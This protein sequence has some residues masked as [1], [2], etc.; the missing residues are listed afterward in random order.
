[1][2]TSLIYFSIPT[3][4]KLL[5]N[6]QFGFGIEISDCIKTVSDMANISFLSEEDHTIFSD[7]VTNGSGFLIV[8]IKYPF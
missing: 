1:M 6:I 7:Y 3:I 5:I 2:Y 8:W 4:Y